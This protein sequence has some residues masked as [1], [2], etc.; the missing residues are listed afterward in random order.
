MKK[1]HYGA[2]DGIRTIACIGI[3]LMH[4]AA[5]N[6]YNISGF[7][8]DSMIPS[9]TNFV[10]LFMMVSAFGMCCGYYEKIINSKFPSVIFMESGLRRSFRFLD[11]L[12]YWTLSCR[13]Q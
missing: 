2:I 1:E 12:F 5:N 8:Y 6:S 7:I 11:C 3:V 9:F 13:H 10:F 4:M